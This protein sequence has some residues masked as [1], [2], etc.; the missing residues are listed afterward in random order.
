M[1]EQ[2]TATMTAEQWQV[3]ENKYNQAIKDDKTSFN[4]M[5]NEVLVQYAKY[6]LEW[7]GGK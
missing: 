1:K 4:F 7:R 2:T 3:L 6:L 5:D